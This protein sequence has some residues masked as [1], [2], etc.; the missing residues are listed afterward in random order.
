MTGR[1]ALPPS[2]IG[3]ESIRRGHAAQS[4][5]PEKQNKQSANL[6]RRYG[7]LQNAFDGDTGHGLA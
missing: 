7:Y 2:I 1:Q 6:Q 3:A 5:E 4:A